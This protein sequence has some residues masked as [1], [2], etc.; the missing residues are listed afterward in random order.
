MSWWKGLQGKVW[1]NE[2]LKGKTTFRIGG[3][4]KFFI[5]PKDIFDLKNLIESAARFRVPI[6]V[7][8]AG[9][10]ILV[11]DAGINGAVIRLSSPYFKKIDVKGNHIMA[12]SGVT[13]NQLILRSVTHSL[14]GLEFLAGIPATLGGVLMM[15]A[16]GW[17]KRIADFVQ[18]IS[19][20]DYAGEVKSLRRKGLSF[21]YRSSNLKKYIIL[22]ADLKLSRKNKKEIRDKIRQHLTDRF[23]TQDNS[24]PNA[25][26][27]FKNPSVRKPAGRIID[28][29][30]LKGSRIGDAFLSSKHANFILNY[31]HASSSD[32]I[33]LMNLIKRRVKDK[34]SINLQ[35]EIKIWR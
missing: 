4:A 15:N 25:G 13:I 35:P 1:L 10:N 3:P 21:R 23:N 22:S 31:G 2:P 19:V 14:S 18:E 29:C 9:S 6:F 16:G 8:G 17:G 27:I 5:E 7:I 12:G 24:R 11:D 34:F 20:M 32:V 26:C 33:K 28:L 30:G